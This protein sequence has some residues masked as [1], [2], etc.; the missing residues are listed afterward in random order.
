[1]ITW[2]FGSADMTLYAY[3]A[4]ES[5]LHVYPQARVRFITVG[6]AYAW[7]YKWANT[8][9]RTQFQKYTKR[10][11]DVEV[12]TGEWSLEEI[13]EHKHFQAH[14]RITSNS[15]PGYGYLIVRESN[16]RGGDGKGRHML[17]EITSFSHGL[18][19]ANKAHRGV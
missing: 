11:Y 4:L 16:E 13:P 8:V 9:S 12:C 15:H 6:P 14:V 2:G 5:L 18:T 10:G 3:R 1:M 7:G 17:L 19:V